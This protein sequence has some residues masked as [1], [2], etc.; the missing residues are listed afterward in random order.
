MYARVTLLELDPVRIDVGEAVET[1]ERDVVPRLRA[2]E[3]YKGAYVLTTA[4]GKGLLMTLWGTETEADAAAGDGF[5]A[6]QIARYMTLFKAPPGRE[7]YRVA[8]VD[9]LAAY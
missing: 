3:G 7:R 1:F 5:Y 9:A 8:L 4:D 2:Q 6:E